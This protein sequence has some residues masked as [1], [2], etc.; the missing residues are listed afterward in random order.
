MPGG[1]AC[2]AGFMQLGRVGQ[3]L[4]VVMGQVVFHNVVAGGVPHAIVA[5]DVVKNFPQVTRVVGLPDLIRM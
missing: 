2:Q 4:V 5:A 3:L 1:R